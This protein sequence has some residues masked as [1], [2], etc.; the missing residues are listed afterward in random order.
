MK[1]EEDI[2]KLFERISIGEAT[3]EDFRAYNLWCHSFQENQRPISDIGRISAE[4]LEQVKNE[5]HNSAK[6]HSSRLW[7]KVAVAASIALLVTFGSYV[8]M[9]NSTTKY[10]AE[11]SVKDVAPGSN[12][13]VLTLANGQTII[14]DSSHNGKLANQNGHKVTKVNNGLITYQAENK[15]SK[16]HGPVE[17]NTLKVPRGGQYQ[18]ILSDG[19]KVWLNA[20]SSIRYPAA[21]KGKERRVFVNGEVYLEVANDDKHPF[22]VHTRRYDITVLG[23][24]FNVM[25]YDNEPEVCTTL[26]EGS[27]MVALPGAEAPIIIKSGQQASVNDLSQAIQV[28][29]VNAENAATWIHGFLSL[30]DCSVQEVMNK[31]SRWY[32]VDIE[33]A[34]T[35]P[36]KKFGGILNRNAE[37]SDVLAV[38]STVGIHTQLEDRKI[39]VSSN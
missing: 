11:H 14:L 22:I 32:N 3:E 28:K 12:K 35:V 17:Y 25:A 20:A 36:E 15:W 4:M 37:L 34:G 19:T 18:L 16:A 24:H 1:K 26:L 29:K 5:I 6:I 23:T 31:L 2:L 8:L 21:F 30:N 7:I 10:T 39:I 33:Y 9:R 27:I 13:A 38:L